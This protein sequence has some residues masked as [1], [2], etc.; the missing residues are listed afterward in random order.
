MG[1]TDLKAWKF[2]KFFALGALL[3]GVFW[4]IQGPPE[5]ENTT[6]GIIITEA[7]V[8]HQKSLWEKTWGRPPTVP[9]LKQ[10]MD[11]YVR[12]EILY[13]EALARE[14]DRLDPRVR[15]A[16]IQKMQ[17]FAAG[18]ADA[19][20]VSEED[21]AS[22][23]ALRKEQYR[24]PAT[25]SIKQVLFKEAGGREQRI[26]KLLAD[27]NDEDVPDAVM[28]ESGDPT[29]LESIHIEVTALDI[30]RRFGSEF[31][32]A[33]L[34][35]PADQ[36]SGPVQ[37]GFGLHVVKV[38]DREPGR[39]PEFAEVRERVEND[40]LYETREAFQE[41]G[42]QEIAVKYKVSITEGA[43]IMLGGDQL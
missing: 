11:G 19:K 40:L 14:M 24:I 12:N 42:Y 38:F 27:A 20:G 21:V 39:I 8:A 28:L 33:V 15:L 5:R 3:A 23:F 16:L 4:A 18:Q 37:S 22:F 34:S 6:P 17:M 41:Q 1:K 43:E 35:L 31:T 26:K 9:E 29:M 7:E 10:A 25:L 32:A 2:A 30:E 13:R 36:W